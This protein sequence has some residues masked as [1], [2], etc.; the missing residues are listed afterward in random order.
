MV[1]AGMIAGSIFEI[2]I[3]VSCLAAWGSMIKGWNDFKKF[4]IKVDWCQFACTTYANVL[5]ELRTYLWGIEFEE[6]SFLI[7][8]QTSD[9]TITDF[10]PPISD[11]RM[12]KYHRH[13][14]YIAVEGMCFADGCPRQPILNKFCL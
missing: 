3:V 8:T 13:F 14:R 9:D 4:P 2:T 5:T 1:A 6:D 10:S 12:L 11:E 7:K